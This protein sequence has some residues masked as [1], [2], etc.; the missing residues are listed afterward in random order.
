[1]RSAI[2][3]TQ[4]ASAPFDAV[5]PAYDRTFVFSRIGQAQRGFTWR[6]LDRVFRP[7]QRILELNCGTGIDAVYLAQRGISV[8]A[9]DISRRMLEEAAKHLEEA[10]RHARL[11][12][13]LEFRVLATECIGALR[14]EGEQFDG[15][16]SNFAGLN[17]V[18]DVSAVARG[19]AALLKPGAPVLL[20]LFGCFCVWEILWYLGRRM[21]AKAFR[22]LR[23]G[24]VQ[25]GL[26][27]GVTVNVYYRSVRELARIFAPEFVLRNWRGIGVA[28]PP[29]YLEHWAQRFPKLLDAASRLDRTLGSYPVFRA[30]ADHVLLLFERLA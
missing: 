20:C 23:G 6:E 8:L 19:L 21:P 25:A 22:R 2:L 14:E 9:C 18:E 7:G 29:A 30:T 5:A 11:K 13:K 15:A 27:E 3:E 28:I 16:F 12:G 10:R 26:S 1:M 4:P 24:R 17:C